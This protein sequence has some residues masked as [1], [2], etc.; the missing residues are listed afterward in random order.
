[1]R[2]LVTGGLGFQGWHIVKALVYR[3]HDVT[4]IN[5]PSSRAR[6]LL[7]QLNKDSDFTF[8]W[9]AVVWGSIT[10]QEILEKT[11]PDHDAIIHLAAW[12]SVDQSLDRPWPPFEVNAI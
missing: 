3:D 8:P 11:I 9:D 10:D 4:I 12:A 6:F 1:M 7:E 2:V 5:T